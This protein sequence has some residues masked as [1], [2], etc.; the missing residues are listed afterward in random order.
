VAERVVVDAVGQVAPD[1]LGA[2]TSALRYGQ[3]L[4]R[5]LAGDAQLTLPGQRGPEAEED[6]EQ[7]R[8]AADLLGE[9]ARPREGVPPLARSVGFGRGQGLAEEYLQL[10]RL[11][12][13]SGRVRQRAEQLEGGREVPGGLAQRRARDGRLAGPLPRA[14]RRLAFARF[15]PVVGD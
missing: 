14:P 12:R 3:H 2:R 4:A 10:E 9:R 7:L 1:H 15:R 5:E 13:A 6:G 8:R 11:L